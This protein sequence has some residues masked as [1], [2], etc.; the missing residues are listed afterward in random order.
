[1]ACRWLTPHRNSKRPATR[2]QQRAGFRGV[3][4]SIVLSEHVNVVFVS[5]A[6]KIPEDFIE[7]REEPRGAKFDVVSMKSAIH[8][9]S[10][11]RVRPE[12]QQASG[13]VTK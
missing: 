7:D 10:V 4:R 6:D 5:Q 11:P 1:M 2:T 3:H 12:L 8:C 13:Q 9:S